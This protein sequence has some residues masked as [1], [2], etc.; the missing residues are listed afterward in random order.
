[1]ALLHAVLR[2]IC[3]DSDWLAVKSEFELTD[4]SPSGQ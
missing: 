4:D 1:M 3:R 2:E